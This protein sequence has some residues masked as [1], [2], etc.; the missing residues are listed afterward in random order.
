MRGQGAGPHRWAR[1]GTVIRGVLAYFF[2]T[3]N[4]TRLLYLALPAFGIA[5]QYVTIY[6]VLT[7]PRW[8]LP[9]NPV[10][11]SMTLVSPALELL[12]DD[13][14]HPAVLAAA[15]TCI[16]AATWLA[17]AHGVVLLSCLLRWVWASTT[18][19]DDW[20]QSGSA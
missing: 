20:S 3:G 6:P 9:L 11:F 18:P 8:F 19:A 5:L 12:T 2:N 14:V 7:V 10:I 1:S 4:R 17:V 15:F 13:G 16:G